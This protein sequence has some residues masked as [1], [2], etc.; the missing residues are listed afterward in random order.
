MQQVFL[1]GLGAVF[2]IKIFENSN[3]MKLFE[4]DDIIE[5]S[6]VNL[7]INDE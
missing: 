7:T 3:P 1:F 4:V 6:S 2:S 5:I